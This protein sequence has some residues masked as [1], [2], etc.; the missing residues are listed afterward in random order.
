MMEI[1]II[2]E[3]LDEIKIGVESSNKIFRGAG[4]AGLVPDP[5]I[6]EGKFLRD[7]GEWVDITD[8]NFV[9]LTTNQ[10]IAGVKTFE[11]DLVANVVQFKAQETNIPAPSVD[12]S[13]M[14]ERKYISEGHKII[15]LVSKDETGEIT[16]LR[17]TKIIL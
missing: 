17:T 12:S 13:Y 16:V 9:D 14:F 6:E 7:D 4:A 10:S 15:E 11:D 5:V 2:V 8:G 3:P 1:Q